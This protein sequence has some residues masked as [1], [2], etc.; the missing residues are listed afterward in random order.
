[1]ASAALYEPVCVPTY[2]VSAWYLAAI[3]NSMVSTMREAE[4][5]VRVRAR[6][7][8]RARVRVRVQVR[9]RVRVR[10]GVGG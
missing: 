6:A 1:M 5:L 7:R 9:V 8:V 4:H 10:V 2:L 3:S